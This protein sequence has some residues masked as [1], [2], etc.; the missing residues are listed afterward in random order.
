MMKYSQYQRRTDYKM[1]GAI[2]HPHTAR[3][4]QRTPHA[5]DPHHHGLPGA[6]QYFTNLF[7]VYRS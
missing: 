4:P 3:Q 2:S 1:W 5:P 6:A 7:Y